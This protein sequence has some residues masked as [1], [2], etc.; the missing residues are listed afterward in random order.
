MPIY[1]G[2]ALVFFIITFFNFIIY[3]QLWCSF[4]VRDMF[5]EDIL[6]QTVNTSRMLNTVH[7]AFGF[8]HILGRNKKHYFDVDTVFPVGFCGPVGYIV[9]NIPSR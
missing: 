6:S 1:I 7:V 5:R 8:G 3:L 4:W 9:E 2:Q